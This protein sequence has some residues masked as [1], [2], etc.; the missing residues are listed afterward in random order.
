MINQLL[1]LNFRGVSHSPGKPGAVMKVRRGRRPAVQD[2]DWQNT[3]IMLV[4]AGALM[5][6]YV[7]MWAN[8]E[9]HPIVGHSGLNKH[10]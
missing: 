2:T 5:G 3:V 7:S 8:A 10:I 1:R 9:A 4:S 6:W